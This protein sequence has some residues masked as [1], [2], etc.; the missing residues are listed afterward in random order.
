M[1]VQRIGVGVVNFSILI[2]VNNRKTHTGKS[3]YFL[4]Q[5]RQIFRLVHIFLLMSEISYKMKDNV[6]KCDNSSD[7]ISHK[8]LFVNQNFT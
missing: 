6:Y 1:N 8:E 4:G 2:I 5:L 3:A 7:I